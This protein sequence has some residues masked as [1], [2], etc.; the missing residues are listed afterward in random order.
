MSNTFTKGYQD[1]SAL[2][3]AELDTAYQTLQLDIANTALATTGSSQG[4]VLTS[5]GSNIAASFQS[6]SDPQGP[7]SIRNYGLKATV[8]SGVMT[9]SLKTKALADP[10]GTDIVN[11][12][13]STNGVT[14]AS[15]NTVNISAAVTFTVSASATLGFTSTSTSRIFVYGYYNTATSSVKLAVSARSDLDRGEAKLTTIMSASADSLQNVYASAA[16]TVV[17]RMLGHVDAAITAAGLW[18]TPSH[19]NITNN[20]DLENVPTVNQVVYSNTTR[21][22][23]T[24]VG[25]GGVAISADCGGFSTNSTVAVNVTNLSVTITT[26]GRP[27]FIGMV[28]SAGGNDTD[29]LNRTC[30]SL[31]EIS[32]GNAYV[33]IKRGA[34]DVAVYFMRATSGTDNQYSPTAPFVID[35]PV[36]GTYTYTVTTFTTTNSNTMVVNY[37]KLIAYEL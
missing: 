22:T 14:S 32:T 7:F 20:V 31:Q 36:A 8:A 11:F 28:S 16:L 33:H 3:E 4:Q 26:A 35:T 34:T 13:Y 21:A 27:V 5:N 2:T 37:Y 25:R 10:S 24:T 29:P 15:Y 6:I 30:L 1:G 9:I 23:G 17:T 19:V 12:N 18:Q